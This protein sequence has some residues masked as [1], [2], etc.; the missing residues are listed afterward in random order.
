M[1]QNG[2]RDFE[3]DAKTLQAGGDGAAQI[4]HAPRNS[5]AGIVPASA[6][7]L[8][9]ATLV[10]VRQDL[11]ATTPPPLIGEGTTSSESSALAH[12]H[13]EQ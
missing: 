5:G 4:V 6:A 2:F 13:V 9:R 1:I 11:Q 8:A 3:P 12:A 10:P 7:A